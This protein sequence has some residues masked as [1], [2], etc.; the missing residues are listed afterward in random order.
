MR[1]THSGSD[2][3]VVQEP[4]GDASNLVHYLGPLRC[5][6]IIALRVSNNYLCAARYN[7]QAHEYLKITLSNTRD[8]DWHI[9]LSLMV[10]LSYKL[11]ITL[12]S[13]D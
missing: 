13:A 6:E 12:I 4:I 10:I 8:N 9:Y 3:R 7:S 5:R 1:Q 2:V 11:L